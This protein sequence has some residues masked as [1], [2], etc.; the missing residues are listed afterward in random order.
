MSNIRT[1][2]TVSRSALE[3]YKRRHEKGLPM[4]DPYAKYTVIPD[5]SCV[6]ADIETCGELELFLSGTIIF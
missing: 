2:K 5:D 3:E 6:K 1:A 4:N